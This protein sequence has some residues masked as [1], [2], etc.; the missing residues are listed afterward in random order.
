M[1]VITFLY[2]GCDFVRELLA[3]PESDHEAVK[4]TNI[5]NL[6]ADIDEAVYDLFEL[7]A[8]EHEVVEE[9]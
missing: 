4:A 1:D 3:R 2:V 6:E 9:D 5:D 7:T 8:D